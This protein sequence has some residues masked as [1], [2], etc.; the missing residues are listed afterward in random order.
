MRT[1]EQI[2]KIA[3]A[4]IAARKELKNPV[5]D[6]TVILTKGGA[7]AEYATLERCYQTVTETLLA[8]GI[9]APQ[10]LCTDGNSVSVRTTLLHESG[11][12]IEYGPFSIPAKETDPKTYGAAA[13]YARRYHLPA[14]LGLVAEKDD[15]GASL[16]E[17]GEK[18]L[19]DWCAY[20]ESAESEDALKQAYI[21]AYK[22]YASDRKGQAAIIASKDKRK[23]ELEH[24]NA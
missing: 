1:S 9:M 17:D 12:F 24:A 8:H 13:T 5:F 21:E 22:N 20:I 6:A 16:A 23:K 14:C 3:P 7:K 4:L 11:Q 18:I 15:G 2:D 19:A 10:E